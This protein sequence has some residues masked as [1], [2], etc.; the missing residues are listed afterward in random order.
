VSGLIL[1]PTVGA[2][3]RGSR[4]DRF[5]TS[6]LDGD[7]NRD[8]VLEVRLGKLQPLP[9]RIQN[10][11]REPELPGYEKRLP[12]APHQPTRAPTQ[13]FDRARPDAHRTGAR[14]L[15][16]STSDSSSR[17]NLPTPETLRPSLAPG[18]MERHR[19][20]RAAARRDARHT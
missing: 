1:T 15:D 16:T 4:C 17:L 12:H 8:D 5:L 20:A 18:R 10:L 2:L 14:S 7:S 6:I 13:A 3:G 19:T 9:S 11:V